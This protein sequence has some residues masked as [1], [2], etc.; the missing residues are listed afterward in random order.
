MVTKPKPRKMQLEEFNKLFVAEYSVE[1]NAFNVRSVNEML[2]TN[3]TNLARRVSSDYAP[4]AFTATY[5][6]VSLSKS[7][8]KIIDQQLKV[9]AERDLLLELSEDKLWTYL[10]RLESDM[11]EE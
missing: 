7:L 6:A 9:G 11:R 8:G 4:I 3:R 10:M 1:Q 5:D 2:E